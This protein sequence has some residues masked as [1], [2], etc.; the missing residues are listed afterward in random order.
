MKPPRSSFSP[1]LSLVLSIITPS[2]FANLSIGSSL[3]PSIMNAAAKLYLT[4][5]SMSATPLHQSLHWLPIAQRIKF[6]IQHT[7]PFI[8]L[9]RA[10]SPILSPNITQTVLLRSLALYLHC[11]HLP[12]SSPEPL[13]SYGSPYPNLSSYLLLWLPSGEP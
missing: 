13:P 9:P 1:S 11:L 3:L 12:C 5:H 10:T 7:K 6:K 2:S 4:N 8:T